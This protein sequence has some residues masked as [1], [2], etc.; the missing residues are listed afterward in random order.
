MNVIVATTVCFALIGCKA[1]QPEYQTRVTTVP[2][3]SRIV[4]IVANTPIRRS[5]F[6]ETLVGLSGEKAVEQFV[7]EIGINKELERKGLALS[8]EDFR[9][10]HE[11]LMESLQ[12]NSMQEALDALSMQQSLTPSQVDSFIRQNA[13][14]RKLIKDKLTVNAAM[15]ERMFQILHGPSAQAKIIVCMSRE[16]AIE[17]MELLDSGETFDSVAMKCSVDSTSK[18]G[19]SIGEI[20]Y[21]DPQWPA[22]LREQ[23]HAIE[24]QHYS[25]PFLMDETWAIVYKQSEQHGS[26]INLDSVKQDVE[27][28]ARLAQE[29]LIMTQHSNQ[30]LRTYK[31]TII[32]DALKQNLSVNRNYSD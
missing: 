20:I 12:V 14:L 28:I 3:A 4:A 10:E 30:I 18:Y 31:P 17:A 7:L 24:L 27:K 11:I 22:S 13:G 26:G 5:E 29:R 1:I 15:I 8:K 19:G 32:D 25:S 23:L 2:E 6:W 21:A 16:G 9:R